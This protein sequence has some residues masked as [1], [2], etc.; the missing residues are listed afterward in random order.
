M[1]TALITLAL[2]VSLSTLVVGIEGPTRHRDNRS[3]DLPESPELGEQADHAARRIGRRPQVSANSRPS[4]LP[5]LRDGYLPPPWRSSRSAISRVPAQGLSSIHARATPRLPMNAAPLDSTS[6]TVE[7]LN[8]GLTVENASDAL[9]AH[10]GHGVLVR[11]IVAD[12]AAATWGL[13][14]YDLIIAIRGI[15]TPT[16]C[17][18][19]YALCS[20][21][22]RPQMVL[23]RKGDRL[24][25]PLR[26]EEFD[27]VQGTTGNDRLHL[28]T[29]QEPHGANEEGTPGQ[30]A[31]PDQPDESSVSLSISCTKNAMGLWN[32]V[33]EWTGKD[34]FVKQCKLQGDHSALEQQ[35]KSLPATIADPIRR[36]VG[37]PPLTLPPAPKNLDRPID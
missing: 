35:L 18:L 29:R 26:D 22:E 9:V 25:L 32:V 8:C 10:L 7:R 36:Q 34:G 23:L 2:L 30:T 17:D 28:S 16:V 5:T 3:P 21:V 31:R 6:Q 4:E 19:V 1:K 24:E 27:D 13:Q 37:L 14:Q 33:G 11:D 12:S 15:Q 20:D